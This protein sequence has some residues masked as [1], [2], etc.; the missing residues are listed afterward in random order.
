ML[1]LNQLF[2]ARE[3][4]RARRVFPVYLPGQPNPCPGCGGLQ[5]LVG[6]VS[7]ECAACATALPLIEAGAGGAGAVRTPRRRRGGEPLAA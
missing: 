5:W 7:A 2:G 4:D 6:R 3:P 1:T